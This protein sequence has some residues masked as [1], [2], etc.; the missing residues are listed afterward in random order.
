ME[1]V[2]NNSKAQDHWINT[3][4]KRKGLRIRLPAG[5]Y[6]Y[7]VVF[8]NGEHMVCLTRKALAAFIKGY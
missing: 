1:D 3:T 7:D 8:P 6:G 5:G 2:V 4:A